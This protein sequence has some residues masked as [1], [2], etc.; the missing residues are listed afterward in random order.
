MNIFFFL[1]V[2]I[3]DKNKSIFYFCD[4][5]DINNIFYYFHFFDTKKNQLPEYIHTKKKCLI[6]LRMNPNRGHAHESY[7]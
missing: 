1:C 7:H 5:D 4:D 2:S 6:S 3:Y